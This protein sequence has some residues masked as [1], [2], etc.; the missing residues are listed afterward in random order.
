LNGTPVVLGNE[1]SIGA[2]ASDLNRFMRVQGIVNELVDHGSRFCGC[3]RLHSWIVRDCVRLLKGYFLAN[4]PGL[5]Q[6]LQR[7]YL[8]REWR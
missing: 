1:K 6:Q 3:D 2:L 5:K 7:Q 8:K 4:L